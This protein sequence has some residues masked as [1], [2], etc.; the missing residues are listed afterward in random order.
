MP[1]NQHSGLNGHT[2][3]PPQSRR[4]TPQQKV[5]QQIEVPADMGLD[6][7]NYKW[8][9]NQTH[10]EVFARLPEYAIPEQVGLHLS[11]HPRVCN[12][13]TTR[14]CSEVLLDPTAPT[15]AAVTKNCFCR[16]S[17]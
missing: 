8:R 7:D 9:Q 1:K 16:V 14:I 5:W 15:T 4:S 11:A 10:V 3:A 13:A 6:C 2:C 12:H 17:R